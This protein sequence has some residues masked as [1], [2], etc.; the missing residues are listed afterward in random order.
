[1]SRLDDRWL[2][3]VVA[4][5]LAGAAGCSEPP[6]SSPYQATASLH[7]FMVW[8]L[9]PAADVLWDSAGYVVTVDGEQDLQPTTD[10]GWASVRNSATVVAESGNL[11]MMPGYRADTE[12]WMEYARGMVDAGIAAREA[13]QA[14]DADAL[15]DAGGQLYN[16]CRACHNRYIIEPAE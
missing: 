8:G 7:D 16:V 1:M 4:A 14:H 5:A 10:E 3:L 11:L 13:A 2:C 9:E 12:D 6:Q 15:F